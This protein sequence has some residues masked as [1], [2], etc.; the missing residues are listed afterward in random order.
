M[1]EHAVIV[2]V[3]PGLGASLARTCAA[4]GM[5]VTMIARR[6]DVIEP[7][8]QQLRDGGTDAQAVVVDVAYEPAFTAALE[9][10]VATRP[11]P[12][13]AVYNAVDATPPGPPST[14]EPEAVTMSLETN[15][16]G[17]VVLVGALLE[18]MRA[19]GRASIIITGGVLAVRPMAAMA[20][21][22]IGKAAL[23]T[24]AMCL[25]QELGTDDPVHAAT[26]TVGGVIAPG[27][28]F[29]PDAIAERMLAVHADRESGRGGEVMYRAGGG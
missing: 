16:T 2:G 12:T 25:H 4:S 27:S 11:T 23:R 19:T 6:P 22:S 1:S 8:A 13:L 24:Y 7:L 20:S 21:L 29:D 14:L 28:D 10:L 17:A 15:V 3:G 9:Q 5:A 18:P 26:V